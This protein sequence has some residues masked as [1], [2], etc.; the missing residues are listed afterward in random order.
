MEYID[1]YLKDYK[2]ISDISVKN[3]LEPNEPLMS[4]DIILTE[5]CNL[6]CKDCSHFCNLI[7]RETNSDYDISL[8]EKDFKDLLKIGLKTQVITLMGGEPFSMSEDHLIKVCNLVRS[9]FPDIV[10]YFITNGIG[11]MRYS[12]KLYGAIRDNDIF[13]CFS[14]YPGLEQHIEKVDEFLDGKKITHFKYRDGGMFCSLKF[15]KQPIENYSKYVNKCYM[16]NRCV[17][18]KNGIISS[19]GR[20]YFSRNFQKAYNTTDYQAIEGKDYFSIS[21]LAG[22]MDFVDL[23][24]L[25]SKPKPF[26]KYCKHIVENEFYCEN[27]KFEVSSNVDRSYYEK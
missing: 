5:Y 25:L 17:M 10:I 14:V 3:T 6:K 7:T 23:K 8:M 11:V 2:F 1:S 26:C 12:E 13:V 24:L 27:T 4:L 9:Y 21:K 22:F 19:C 15:S 16:L 18:V 20:D